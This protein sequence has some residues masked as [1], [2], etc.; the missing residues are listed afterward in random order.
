MCRLPA[1]LVAPSEAT[2]REACCTYTPSIKKG[3][4]FIGREV[5]RAP[6]N[7]LYIK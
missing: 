1:A 5:D 4:G 7:I 3:K 2:I 6:I